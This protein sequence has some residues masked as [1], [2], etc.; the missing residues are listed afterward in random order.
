MT[1]NILR[2]G[3]PIVLGVLAASCLTLRAQV[4]VPVGAGSYASFVPAADQ[5]A[6]E[7]YAP[8]RSNS[9]ICTRSCIWTRRSPAGRCPATSG[10]RTP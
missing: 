9:L 5:Q 2:L 4:A 7:Y 8:A 3:L 6:D 10:G 1:A